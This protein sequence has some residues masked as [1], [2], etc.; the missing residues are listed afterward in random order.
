M[1]FTSDAAEMARSMEF[2][3]DPRSYGPLHVTS[4]GFKAVGCI[5]PRDEERD[6]LNNIIQTPGGA[7]GKAFDSALAI[8]IYNYL[9]AEGDDSVAAMLVRAASG[10]ET[11]PG[12]VVP[13]VENNTFS[14]SDAH[15]SSA[16]NGGSFSLVKGARFD[17]NLL[18]ST[19]AT[20]H[21]T[22]KFMGSLALIARE[23]I[24]PSAFTLETLGQTIARYQLPENETASAI[25]RVQESILRNLDFIE[26]V[27]PEDFL[28]VIDQMYPMHENVAGMIG[29]NRAG[30]Y[31]RNHHPNVGLRRQSVHRGEYPLKVHA[32]HDNVRAT[33]D[34]LQST[35]GMSVEMKLNRL[36]ALLLRSSATPSV[37]I[38]DDKRFRLLDLVPTTSGYQ[39]E[40]HYRGVELSL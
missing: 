35:V 20:A 33:M 31:I 28:Q 36:A 32:Y 39:V 24:K 6:R 22:C 16:T 34:N 4:R 17:H 13:G 18:K 3:T 25:K 1:S 14:F 7:A 30:I 10:S 27:S 29:E 2:F 9:D 19:V 37:L 21:P 5:D 40:E 11:E 15:E 12:E 26:K 8:D 38:G 23:Y